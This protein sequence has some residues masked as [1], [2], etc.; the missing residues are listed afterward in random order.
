MVAVPDLSLVGAFSFGFVA[1]M[2]VL[3]AT[4]A[5]FTLLLLAFSLQWFDAAWLQADAYEA[6][7]V[8]RG[9]ALGLIFLSFVVVTVKARLAGMDSRL[10]QA[11]MDLYANEWQTFR[12]VT[13]PL[14]VPFASVGAEGCRNVSAEP[15]LERNCSAIPGCSDWRRRLRRLPYTQS[16]GR[17]CRCSGAL[18]Q[19]A[20]SAPTPPSWRCS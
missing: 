10:E 6:G 2:G 1:K 19:R 4:I 12:L 14:A 16:R 3:A 15:R 17:R 5:V 9:V 8:A 11:A 13:L 7:L 18:N 20:R